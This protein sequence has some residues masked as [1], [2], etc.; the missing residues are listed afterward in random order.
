MRASGAGVR[1]AW[2]FLGSTGAP[3]RKTPLPTPDKRREE[4][5]LRCMKEQVAA[6]AGGPRR[7]RVM[8]GRP[9]EG[10]GR[11]NDLDATTAA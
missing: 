6:F 3:I 2:D 8:R 11:E 1:I 4:D 7:K 10:M 9:M 5:D